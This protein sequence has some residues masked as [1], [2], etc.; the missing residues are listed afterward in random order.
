MTPPVKVLGDPLLPSDIEQLARTGISPETAEG[1]FLRRV[2]SDTGASFVGR[3]AGS[4]D[5][6][7]IVFPYIWPGEQHVRE[8][9]LRRDHP[10]MEQDKDGHLKPT[11]KYLGPPDRPPKLY[12]PPGTAPEWLLDSGLPVLIVEGEKKAL[13][14]WELSWHGLGEAADRPRWLTIAIAG[15]WG[16]RGTT[17]KTVAADGSRVPV[18]GPLPDFDRIV[19]EGREVK[20]LFDADVHSNEKVV[21]ARA[22]LARDQHKRKGRVFFVDIPAGA[23]ANGVDDLIGTWGPDPVLNLIVTEAYE[24]GLTSEDKQ[25]PRIDI[26]AIPSIAS[27]D[28]KGIDYVVP[29]LIAS[30]AVTMFTGESGH[31]KSTLVT[32]LAAAIAQGGDFAGRPCSMRPVLILDREN[33]I[34]VLKERFERLNITDESGLRVWGGWLANEAPAP[35]CS[36]ILEWVL[37]T[38]PRPVVV[39]DSLIA[40]LE[41]NENSATEVREFMKQLRQLANLGATVIVLHHT[42]KA[43]TAQQY[44]GSSDLKGAIDIGINIKNMGEGVLGRIV[45]QAFKARFS[46]DQQLVLNYSGGEFASDD[47]PYAVARTVTERLTSLLRE[48]PGV[49]KSQFENLANDLKLGRNRAR[50]YI[51]TGVMVGEIR[52][53]S[54]RNNALYHFLAEPEDLLIGGIHAET[55]A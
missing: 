22:A 39:I 54:G 48:H 4:G 51:Q 53:E 36:T 37:A 17:S 9:R 1:A 20:I 8:Y 47:R 23:G 38:E 28:S 42:G 16:W 34:D 25:E 11:A 6:S 12:I 24:P 27:F 44:R 43:E 41:G 50:S 10:E 33:G 3:R 15:V 32:S 30:G 18:K 52:V 29:G 7:G 14:A 2:D 46:V 13:S 40:F 49:T 35:A 45:L 55:E 26:N 5:Y 19:W 21:H 31:G